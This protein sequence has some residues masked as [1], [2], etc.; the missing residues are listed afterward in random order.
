MG[1]TDRYLFG[2]ID[3]LVVCPML[4]EVM[5]TEGTEI[6]V[7]SLIVSGLMPGKL[8]VELFKGK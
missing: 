4:A 7:F 5:A 2:G 3:S 8:T 1:I 6:P